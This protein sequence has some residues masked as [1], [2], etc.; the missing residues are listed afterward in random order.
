VPPAQ[1]AL[2]VAENRLDV[3]LGVAVDGADRATA[4]DLPAPPPP[5]AAGLPADLLLNRPDLRALRHRLVATDHLVAAAV[6]DRLPRLTLTG[7]V[8]VAGSADGVSPVASLL[9]GVFQ[10]LI[11]WG[12]RRAAADEQRAAAAE[13]LAAFSGAYLRAIAEVDDL[14][15]QEGRAEAQLALVERRVATLRDNLAE[16]EHRYVNGL[17]DY[18]PVLTAVEDLQEAER[19]RLTLRR[20]RLT[21]R[22]AL[23]RALGGP[24]PDGDD[25]ED[26]T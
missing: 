8:G 6:A 1:A 10:P 16:A 23:H 15:F 12:A 17:S 19:Q 24:L 22:V 11:D 9:A 20:E 26:A 14:L 21:L 13:L 4:D 3:L 7:S 5:L 25:E 18:L 2:R